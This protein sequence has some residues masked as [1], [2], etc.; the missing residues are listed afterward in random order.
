MP[1][2]SEHRAKCVEAGRAT[3]F[4]KGWRPDTHPK[5]CKADLGGGRQCKAWALRGAKYCKFHGGYKGGRN[6]VDKSMPRIYRRHMTQSLHAAVQEQMA[7]SP[8]EQLQLFEELALMREVAQQSVRLYGAASEALERAEAE[9]LEEPKRKKLEELTMSAG[10]VLQDQ[11]RSVSDICDRAARIDAQVKD[12]IS[13]HTLHHFVD[14]IVMIAYK[15]F[16][17]LGED[18]PLVKDF[19]QRI[20]T[21]IKIPSTGAEGTSVTPDMDVR[22]MD[23]TV[24]RAPQVPD[25]T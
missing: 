10:M 8:A 1:M 6:F 11:M 12:K 17:E 23:E 3:Q 4:K 18:S 16:G 15:S 2:S 24:P 22:D 14:Q 5:F 25:S 9:G 20:R 19:V 21:E 13:V 7:V